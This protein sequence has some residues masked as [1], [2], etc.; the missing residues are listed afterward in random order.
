MMPG[1]TMLVLTV[2]AAA[3]AFYGHHLIR[4]EREGSARGWLALAGFTTNVVLVVGC[5]VGS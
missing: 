3:A 2:T 4:V 5:L 1:S